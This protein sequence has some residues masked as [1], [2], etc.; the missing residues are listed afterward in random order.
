M[1]TITIDEEDYLVTP[2]TQAQVVDPDEDEMFLT[3]DEID[4]LV[5]LRTICGNG[6]MQMIHAPELAVIWFY[7]KR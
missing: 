6:I 2:T 5:N 1:F 7:K 3:M 4:V